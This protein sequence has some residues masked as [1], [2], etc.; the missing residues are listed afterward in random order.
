M[1]NKAR[2]I[3]PAHTH[4]VAMITVRFERSSDEGSLN[5]VGSSESDALTL[6]IGVGDGSE[7]VLIVVLAV[8]VGVRLMTL[9]LGLSRSEGSTDAACTCVQSIYCS[10][11]PGL[12]SLLALVTD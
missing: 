8:L 1:S 5:V 6:P 10:I 12:A 7:I 3:P 11:S 2:I 4:P 9:V